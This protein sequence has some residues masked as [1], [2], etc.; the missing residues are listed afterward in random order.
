M[1]QQKKLKITISATGVV[2]I[3]VEGFAGESCLDATKLIEK[4][5]GKVVSREKTD[6]YYQEPDEV[7]E[8]QGIKGRHSK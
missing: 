1:S 8:V 4:A 7:Y 5:I 6:E 3:A 2:T